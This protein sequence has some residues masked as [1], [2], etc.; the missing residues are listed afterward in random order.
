MYFSYMYRMGLALY[1]LVDLNIEDLRDTM[2]DM[3]LAL[4]GLMD[5]NDADV[6]VTI[7]ANRSSSI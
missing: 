2:V 6:K 7:H 3:S 1:E 5:L 4:Y